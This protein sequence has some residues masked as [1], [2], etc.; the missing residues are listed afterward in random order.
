MFD[1]PHRDRINLSPKEL[2][3][4][5]M[6]SNTPAIRLERA[7]QVFERMHRAH[8]TIAVC[9]SEFTNNRQRVTR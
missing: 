6:R 5:A 9:T 7:E 2:D 4:I 1:W 3:S 8:S